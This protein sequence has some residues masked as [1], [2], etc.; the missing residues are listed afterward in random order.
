MSKTKIKAKKFVYYRLKLSVE[1]KM[2]AV[3]VTDVNIL[4]RATGYAK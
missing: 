3:T 2:P 1:E 4:V